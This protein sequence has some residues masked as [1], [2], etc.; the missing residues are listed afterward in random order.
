M[1]SISHRQHPLVET[2]NVK[3]NPRSPRP[4]PILHR[5]G[6]GRNIEKATVSLAVASALLLTGCTGSNFD[7]VISE[8][9]QV[10]DFTRIA[11]SDGMTL[12]LVVDEEADTEVFAIYDRDL[13]DQIV[14]EVDGQTLMLRAEG[15]F[16]LTGPRR[17][18]EVMIAS[19]DAL[20]A[21]G[22]VTVSGSGSADSFSVE[23]GGGSDVDLSLFYVDEAD[24]KLSG[25]AKVSLAVSERASGSVTGGASIKLIGAP[26]TEDLTVDGGGQVT[27]SDGE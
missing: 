14:T 10:G 17:I 20:T 6:I 1:T 26:D 4:D 2:K 15:P 27:T 12:N 23:A 21:V 25:G 16:N 3:P 8:S 13:L 19:L 22:G 18:V 11:V 7:H 9:R 5:H 24:L